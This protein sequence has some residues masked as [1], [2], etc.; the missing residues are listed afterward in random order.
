MN[1]SLGRLMQT[2]VTRGLSNIGRSGA[3]ICVSEDTLSSS[4]AT[5]TLVSRGGAQLI[6]GPKIDVPR[7]D[8]LDSRALIDGDGRRNV[9]RIAQNVVDDLLA[10]L[11]VQ[12][13]RGAG[14]L[15]MLRDARQSAVD[16]RD[17]QRCAEAR[18]EMIV[19]VACDAGAPEFI[20]T[21]RIELDN[22]ACRRPR[23]APKNKEAAHPLRDL[24]ARLADQLAAALEQHN[25]AVGAEDIEGGDTGRHSR[26]FG[27]DGG[28]E[29]TVQEIAFRDD[30]AP[31][32]EH[33]GARRR[34]DTR[35]HITRELPVFATGGTGAIRH[36]YGYE[37]VA[38]TIRS[39]A[40]SQEHRRCGV[41]L[42]GQLRS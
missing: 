27:I 38:S 37:T 8:H 9:D 13:D 20:G 28:F 29:R 34:G 10:S 32:R 19:D 5:S 31:R 1:A 14:R 2:S 24:T 41:T 42:H 4:V 35:R 21:G 23:F 12:N 33:L 18:P 16:H 39:L 17:Q 25:L 11:W 15:L 7:D 26:Q 22:N 6:H 3:S 30:E 40:R 36:R